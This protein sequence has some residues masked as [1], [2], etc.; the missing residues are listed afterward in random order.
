MFDQAISRAYARIADLHGVTV[1][2]LIAENTM[3]ESLLSMIARKREIVNSVTD[4]SEIINS[5]TE[6]RVD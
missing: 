3:D 6:R 5:I 1:Y 4:G 2:Q